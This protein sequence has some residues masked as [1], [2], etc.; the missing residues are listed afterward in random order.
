MKI[1]NILKSY[2]FNKYFLF[3]FLICVLFPFTQLKYIWGFSGYS[4][5]ANILLLF[6]SLFT[7]FYWIK[8]DFINKKIWYKYMFPCFLIFIST[9][10]NISI[11]VYSDYNNISLVGLLV[12]MAINLSIPYFYH[13]NMLNVSSIWSFS[14]KLILTIVFLGL[15]DYIYIFLIGFNGFPI[16]TASGLFISGYFS[17]Y[18]DLGLGIPY[19]RFYSCFGEPG[20]L[21]MWLIPFILYALHYKKYIGLIILFIGF[22]LSFSLG[23]IISLGLAIFIRILLLKKMKSIVVL[24]LFFGVLSFSGFDSFLNDSYIE[25][26]KSATVREDNFKT[27]ISNALT[28]IFTKPF[29]LELSSKTSDNQN[30]N[31]YS[32]SN[33]SPTTYLQKGGFLA[34]FGILLL[35]FFSI[36]DSFKILL[37]KHSSNLSVI[38]A[39]TLICYFPYIF[40]RM[41][42]WDSVMFSWLFLP[43][44]F[45]YNRKIYSKGD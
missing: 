11:S 26:G 36:H 4:K 37:N 45:N 33:F 31:L 23:G 9:L 5:L 42:L 43:V 1:L 20:D 38:I 34:F 7:F 2:N 29:G 32:G 10:I 16:E 39:I 17:I 21:A 14:Y 18:H 12:P 6:L 44:L 41:T 13:R 19:F 25:K 3:I 30:Q 24:I 27:G 8:N 35:I 40:Q 15:L 28:I 22:I